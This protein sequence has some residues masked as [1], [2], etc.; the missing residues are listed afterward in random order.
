MEDNLIRIFRDRW[1]AVAQIERQ[2]QRTA[3]M[4]QR[5]Q[6]LNSIHNLA[7]GLGLP[8][9]ESDRQEEIV[10]QRWIKIKDDYEKTA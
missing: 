5:W 8:L 10:R 2:E 6:Q 9:G 3:S 7:L 4:F 1:Q